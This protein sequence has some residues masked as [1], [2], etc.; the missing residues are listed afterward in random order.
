MDDYLKYFSKYGSFVSVETASWEG[1]RAL[2]AE[3]LGIEQLPE[4]FILGEMKLM[5]LLETNKIR[6][7]MRQARDCP[8]TYGFRSPLSAAFFIPNQNLQVFIDALNDLIRKFYRQRQEFCSNYIKNKMLMRQPFLE[9]AFKAYEQ[10]KKNID[11]SIFV[12]KFLDRV[13]SRYPSKAELESRFKISYSIY[14]ILPPVLEDKV[15]QEKCEKDINQKLEGFVKD[16]IYDA[17]SIL[18]VPF[19][20]LEN[21]IDEDTKTTKSAFTSVRRAIKSFDLLNTFIGDT[22]VK[23][24]IDGILK[25]VLLK[26]SI[27]TI[28]QDQ[29]IKENLRIRLTDVLKMVCSEESHEIAI[30][31]FKIRVLNKG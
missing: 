13:E 8:C 29:E 12:N 27:Q 25:E 24:A 26:E 18:R 4:N 1:S 7:I 23:R 21:R 9:A 11:K 2:K 14:S 10:S 20:N 28:L 6:L 3:D 5:P 17:R 31:E 19:Q 22:H 15:L 16:I 30:R